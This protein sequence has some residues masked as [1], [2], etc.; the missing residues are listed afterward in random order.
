VCLA[1]VSGIVGDSGASADFARRRN[2]ENAGFGVVGL[3]DVLLA[4]VTGGEDGNKRR[5]CGGF[6]YVGAALRFFAL[7]QAHDTDDF[8]TEFA[9]GFDGLDGGCTGGADVV[10]DYDASAFFAE[11]FDALS[12]A[13]LLFGFAHEESIE[14]AA[15]DGNGDDNWIGAHGQAADGLGFP[16]AVV[17]FVE[18]NFTRE[19]RALG[20][21]R[22]SAAVDV[23]VAGGSGR[24]LEFA[25]AKRFVS[26]RAQQLLPRGMHKNLR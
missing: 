1:K 10:D 21:E 19:T 9:G 24:E 17:N 2:G 6:F 3:Q 26:Q 18:E 11:A 12:G 5:G 22:G 16:S 4:Y 13:V 20:V 15:D 7:Y 25:E 14:L 23:V 8:E